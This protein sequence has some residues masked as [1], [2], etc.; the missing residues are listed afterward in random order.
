MRGLSGNDTF[1]F[2]EG[3]GENIIND[4]VFDE[5]VIRLDAEMTAQLSN[6][7]GMTKMSLFDDASSYQGSILFTNIEYDEQLTFE[8]FI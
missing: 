7:S 8:M 3:A 4:F 6:K 1:V 2:A 5:D